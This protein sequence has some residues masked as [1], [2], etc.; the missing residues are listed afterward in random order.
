MNEII[1]LKVILFDLRIIYLDWFLIQINGDDGAIEY[2]DGL[3][4]DEKVE[5]IYQI[6]RNNPQSAR[7]EIERNLKYSF[8]H[9]SFKSIQVDIQTKSMMFTEQSPSTFHVQHQL[10]IRNRNEPFFTKTWNFQFP[11]INNWI[12]ARESFRIKFNRWK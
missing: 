1:I 8:P 3:I 7:I 9:H 5:S 12:F 11:R 4:F 2:S 10:N 6:Q